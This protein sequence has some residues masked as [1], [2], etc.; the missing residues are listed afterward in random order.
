MGGALAVREALQG[1]QSTR[2][3]AQVLQ[4]QRGV[5]PEVTLTLKVEGYAGGEATVTAV[6]SYV[7]S[8]GKVKDFTNSTNVTN[9]V[10]YYLVPGDRV[11]IW[12]SPRLSPGGTWELTRIVRFGMPTDVD[13]LPPEEPRLVGALEIQ[14]K[15]GKVRFLYT[16]RNEGAS[17]FRATRSTAQEFDFMAFHNESRIWRWS[18][19]RMFAQIMRPLVV[20]PG[21]ELVYEAEW[22]LK[23]SKGKPVAAG[24]YRVLAY[25]PSQQ[26]RLA[27]AETTLDVTD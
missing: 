11:Y 3:A 23:D 19:G 26:G 16:V 14:P 4:V 1:S 21:Q 5:F 24:I 17:D 25:I 22:D 6:P 2:Y 8:G 9:L 10:A 12:P 13:P 7:R 20:K 15:D 27:E 18:D